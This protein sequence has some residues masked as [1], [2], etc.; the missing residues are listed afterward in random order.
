MLS[1]PHSQ[2]QPLKEQTGVG[3]QQDFSGNI[4]LFG[5]EPVN[6]P[7]GLSKSQGSDALG[8]TLPCL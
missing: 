3:N 4:L 7:S 5:P 2:V 1:S 8:E 6:F